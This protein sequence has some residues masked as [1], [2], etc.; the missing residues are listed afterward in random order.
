MAQDTVGKTR[1]TK[2]LTEAGIQRIRAPAKG[3]IEI[4]DAIVAG[5]RFRITDRDKRSWSLIY[6]VAGTSRLQQRV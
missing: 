2:R 6:R 3:R 5:L 1:G 4:A